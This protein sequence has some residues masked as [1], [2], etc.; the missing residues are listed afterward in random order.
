MVNGGGQI[1]EP[2]KLPKVAPPR[3]ASPRT[4]FKPAKKPDFKPQVDQVILSPKARE[5]SA[6]VSRARQVSE[7]STSRVEAARAKV[8]KSGNSASQNAKIAEK[9]LTES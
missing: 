4:N 3:P 7:V 9:L 8:G 6:I 1:P 2:S 5:V